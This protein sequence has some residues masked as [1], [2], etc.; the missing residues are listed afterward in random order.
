VLRHDDPV[1]AFCEGKTEPSARWLREHRD[2]VT[3]PQKNA[4]LTSAHFDAV[5]E[6]L[7]PDSS[8]YFEH[9]E[10]AIGLD[11]RSANDDRGG[12]RPTFDYNP[13]DVNT[14]GPNDWKAPSGYFHGADH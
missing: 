6:G 5:A 7:T 14:H 11:R 8:E 13:A 1:E 9:V 2:W 10:R 4:R 3:N 12:R